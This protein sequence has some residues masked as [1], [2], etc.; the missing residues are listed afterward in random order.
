MLTLSK[1]AMFLLS[2]KN[3]AGLFCSNIS[4]FSALD[5]L[6]AAL[7]PMVGICPTLVS[8]PVR[9]RLCTVDGQCCRASRHSHLARRMSCKVCNCKKLGDQGR[10]EGTEIL[11]GTHTDCS[12]SI[13]IMGATTKQPSFRDPHTLGLNRSAKDTYSVSHTF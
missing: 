11:A 13:F 1:P 10:S 9:V 12:D 4:S 7:T 3:S 6:G 5:V 2:A 8:C